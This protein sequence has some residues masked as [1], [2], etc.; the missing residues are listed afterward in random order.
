MTNFVRSLPLLGA[1]GMSRGPY[2]YILY[3]VIQ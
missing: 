2:G 3:K 1:S